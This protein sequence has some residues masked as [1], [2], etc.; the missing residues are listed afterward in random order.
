MT[1]TTQLPSPATEP[2]RRTARIFGTPVDLWT[3]YCVRL[4]FRDRLIGGIPKDPKLIEGWLR[5]RAGVDDPQDL[6]LAVLRTLEEVGGSTADSPSEDGL[7]DPAAVG[8]QKRITGFKVGADGL[9]VEGRQVKAML[10][11]STNIVFAGE[12]WGPTRKAARAFL[13]ERVFVEPDK[14]LLDVQAPTGVE[15]VVGHIAG[16]MGP[17]STLTNYEY[18]E[19]PVIEF[20]VL[21]LRDC[22][23]AEQWRDIWSHA[24]EN[25]FGT[26]RSQGHGRFDVTQWERLA[27]PPN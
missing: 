17:R 8:S 23:A 26:L 2:P 24:Q 25:G 13:A 6:R 4:A 19:Q 18:V 9:Y 1:L 3:T 21:V 10:K 16:P 20:R 14:L 15:L 27:T 22:I 5:G 7:V 11:E 12:R